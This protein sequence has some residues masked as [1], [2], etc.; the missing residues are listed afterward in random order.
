VVACLGV[1]RSRMRRQVQRAHT[2]TERWEDEGG[3]PRGGRAA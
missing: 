1:R 3:A 2:A